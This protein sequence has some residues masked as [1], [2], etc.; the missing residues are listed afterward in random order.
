ME[1]SQRQLVID[2]LQSSEADLLQHVY[3][4]TSAQWHF[5]ES[6]ARWSIAENF[7][8]LILFETFIRSAIERTL[9]APAEPEKKY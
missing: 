1:P 8:H 2:Q 9:A 6:P 4:L 7:E 5:R 3:N